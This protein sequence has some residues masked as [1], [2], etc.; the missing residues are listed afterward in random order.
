VAAGALPTELTAPGR[1]DCTRGQATVRNEPL[2]TRFRLDRCVRAGKHCAEFRLSFLQSTPTETPNPTKT[3]AVRKSRELQPVD[4][5]HVGRCERDTERRR[6]DSRGAHA[7]ARGRSSMIAATPWAATNWRRQMTSRRRPYGGGR[8]GAQ[9]LGDACEE[10]FPIADAARGPAEA[11][12]GST[13]SCRRLLG[14]GGCRKCR[15]GRAEGRPGGGNRR[16]PEEVG[17]RRFT[18]SSEPFVPRRRAR[19]R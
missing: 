4:R 19:T 5:F 10:R 13:K 6:S 14:E 18:R 9:A 3:N 15:M 16:P 8:E 1:R 2:P 7:P 11:V 17:L 12:R